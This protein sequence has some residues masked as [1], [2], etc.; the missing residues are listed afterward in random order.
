MDVLVTYPKTNEDK[1]NISTKD[2]NIIQEKTNSETH[3]QTP[4]SLDVMGRGILTFERIRGK[5]LDQGQDDKS[6]SN[7]R[8]T[9]QGRHR[10][11]SGISILHGKDRTNQ[12]TNGKTKHL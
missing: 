11:H 12:K 10:G 2:K 9:K 8:H 6:Q 4:Q 1:Q 7:S 5:Q 3:N